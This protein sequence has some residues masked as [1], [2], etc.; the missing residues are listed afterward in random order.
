MVFMN[1]AHPLP[2]T[3][4]ECARVPDATNFQFV[5]GPNGYTIVFPHTS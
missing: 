5:Q 4:A 1:L 2:E 3:L